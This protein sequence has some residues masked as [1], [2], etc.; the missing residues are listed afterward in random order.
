[1]CSKPSGAI[2]PGSSNSKMIALLGMLVA[3]DAALRL[4]PSLLGA[5]PIFLL[6][7][8]VGYAYGASFGFLMGSL[9]LLVSAFITGGWVRGSRSRCLR[10][11]GSV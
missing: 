9:T 11:A 10:L 3:V 4:I 7:I 8:L 5:S 6:I 2:G 1:L